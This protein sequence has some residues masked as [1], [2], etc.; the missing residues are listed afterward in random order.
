MNPLIKTLANSS[1]YTTLVKQIVKKSDEKL[2]IVGLTDSSKAWMLYG[3]TQNTN[4]SSIIVCSN[5]F[6]ANKIIQDLKFY[7]NALGGISTTKSITVL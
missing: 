5:V 2:S 7:A 3:I 4:K 6:Q 1:N